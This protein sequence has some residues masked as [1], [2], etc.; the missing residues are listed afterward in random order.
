MRYP[1]L[2]GT[3]C[4]TASVFAQHGTTINEAQAEIQKII[5]SN[6]EGADVS[7]LGY[8][9]D[10]LPSINVSNAFGTYKGGNFVKSNAADP[11]SWWGKQITSETSV[12]PRLAMPPRNVTARRDA[13][14]RPIVFPYPRPD[15]AWARNTQYKGVLSTTIIYHNTGLMEHLRVAKDGDTKTGAGLILVGKTESVKKL[16]DQML[17]FHLTRVN[18]T[19]DLSYRNPYLLRALFASIELLTCL[20][21]YGNK[22]GF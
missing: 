10:R 9:W 13:S 2:I 17:F 15:I 22:E 16:P 18:Q 1:T 21:R 5:A 19:V 3:L 14:G 11:A 6:S 20:R 12:N 7:V 8:Y 4:L